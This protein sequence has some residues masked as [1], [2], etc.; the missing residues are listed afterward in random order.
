MIRKD[1]KKSTEEKVAEYK[2]ENFERYSTLVQKRMWK[3][4]KDK[5]EDVNYE[6]E[7]FTIGDVSLRGRIDWI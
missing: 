3:S 7:V 1:K 4:T 5:V 2:W 6:R